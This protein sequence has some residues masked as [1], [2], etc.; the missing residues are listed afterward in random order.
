MLGSRNKTKPAANNGAVNAANNAATC[1]IAKGTGIEGKFNATEDVRLDGSIK[2]DFKCDKRLVMGTTGV[3]KGTLI[4]NDAIIMGT[5]EG[6]IKVKD[7]LVLKNTAVIQ[8]NIFA[9]SM[10]VEEGAKYNGE[11]HVGAMASAK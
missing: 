5:V 9:K 1:V 11:C 3:I 10:S 8:G 4:A 6:E 2:G 7:T